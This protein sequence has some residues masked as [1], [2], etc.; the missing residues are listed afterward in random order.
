[1]RE[2]G[3]E[4]GRAG[5][6]EEGREGRKGMAGGRKGRGGN[7]KLG[8]RCVKREG[9]FQLSLLLMILSCSV[10]VCGLV[11][12]WNYP[13]MMLAWKMGPCLA[14]GNTLVIKPA[15]ASPPPPSLPP[16]SVSLTLALS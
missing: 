6:R 10:R 16:S 5:E 11:V 8:S 1:M 15:E 2:G 13:L 3:R 4:G 12:P 14:A 9:V 7:V